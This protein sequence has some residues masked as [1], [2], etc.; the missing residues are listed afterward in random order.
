MT[1]PKHKLLGAIEMRQH[2]EGSAGSPPEAYPQQFMDVPRGLEEFIPSY[3]ANRKEEVPV[4]IGLLAASDFESL[5]VLG[6][7]IKGSGASFGFPEISRI[8]AA[9]QHSAEQTDPAA[10][11]TQLTELKDYLD[12]VEHTGADG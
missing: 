9:L 1:S 7:N 10:L 8:G 3:L 11:R 5:A 12:Y 2:A 4:M 6:H